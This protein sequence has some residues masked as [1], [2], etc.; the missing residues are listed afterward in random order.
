MFQSHDDFITVRGHIKLSHVKR[1]VGQRP[2]AFSVHCFWLSSPRGATDSTNFTGSDCDKVRSVQAISADSW[3]PVF[4]GPQFPATWRLS[5][6]SRTHPGHIV[7]L[8]VWCP[9][10]RWTQMLLPG[11]GLQEL[12]GHLPGARPPLGWGWILHYTHE[13]GTDLSGRSEKASLSKGQ[14]SWNLKVK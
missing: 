7:R 14:F 4:T 8:S 6:W 3:D 2:G 1:H 10:P 11:M 9:A 13:N 5:C 12:G